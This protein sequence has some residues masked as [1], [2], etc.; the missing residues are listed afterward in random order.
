M[1]R[2]EKSLHRQKMENIWRSSRMAGNAPSVPEWETA[3]L[4][5]SPTCKG[6]ATGQG[7]GQGS[8]DQ[9]LQRAGNAPLLSWHPPLLLGT[10]RQSRCQPCPRTSPLPEAVS[11]SQQRALGTRGLEQTTANRRLS[12]TLTSFLPSLLGH[13]KVTIDV[14]FSQSNPRRPHETEE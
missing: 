11:P 10:P 3:A 5:Q 4:K 2:E 1:P 8:G 9:P 14:S 12:G 7:P 6:A 13:P